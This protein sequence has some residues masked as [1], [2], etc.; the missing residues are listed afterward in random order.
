MPYSALN[1]RLK[2]AESVNPQRAAMAATG[3]VLRLARA[4]GNRNYQFEAHEGVGSVHFTTGNLQQ[5]ATDYES[6]LGLARDLDQHSDE[7]RAHQ[8][9]A[10]A[11]HALGSRDLAREHWQQALEILTRLGI[12]EI[13]VVS[14]DEVR[15]NLAALDDQHGVGNARALR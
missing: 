15:A 7:V 1:I 8:G 9:L 14:T 12:A 13:E 2:L 6:A 11:Y 10:R 4:I 3:R 5:A